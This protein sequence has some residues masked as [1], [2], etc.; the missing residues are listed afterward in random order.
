MT[1]KPGSSQGQFLV[2]I[3]DGV[4]YSR[5]VGLGTMNNSIAF[6][7]FVG[8]VGDEGFER[9]IFDLSSCTG[10]DST[11]MGILLGV[12]H[13]GGRVV[14]VNTSPRHVRILSEVGI[15]TVVRIREGQTVLPAIPLQKLDQKPIQQEARLRAIL[16]AHENLVR[17]DPRNAEKFDAFVR[18]M[19]KE[20][21]EKDS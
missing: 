19:R 13:R 10:F 15:D 2:A 8:H 21:G 14:L 1:S 17:H 4:V 5:V 3:Q 12:V 20:L 11:F 6:Q 7:R 18:L 9:F 16:Q